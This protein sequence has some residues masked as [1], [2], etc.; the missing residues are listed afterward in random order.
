M[1]GL[2]GGVDSSVTAALCVKALGKERVFG[3][4]MPEKDSSDETI[5]LSRLVANHLEIDVLEEDITEI[6]EGVGC[7]RAQAASRSLCI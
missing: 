4:L 1:V 2:S 3:L 7:Y 6:L 5:A